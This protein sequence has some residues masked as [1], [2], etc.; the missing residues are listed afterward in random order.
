M[1]LSE[2]K[3]CFLKTNLRKKSSNYG[4]KKGHS[5]L[6]LVILTKHEMLNF[7]EIQQFERF[8]VIWKTTEK[9]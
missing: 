2:I 3:V 9:T 1:N 4:A 8:S 7:V 5:L 6:I